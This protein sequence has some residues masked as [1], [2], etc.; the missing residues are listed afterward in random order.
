MLQGLV[1]AQADSTLTLFVTLILSAT[2][3]L[4]VTVTLSISRCDHQHF[5]HYKPKHDFY[6]QGFLWNQNHNDVVLSNTSRSRYE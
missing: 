4:S 6:G 2:L 5:V 1:T 3:T